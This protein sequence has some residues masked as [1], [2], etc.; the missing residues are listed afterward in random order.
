V[1]SLIPECPHGWRG[2]VPDPKDLPDDQFR[3]IRDLIEE[4]VKALLASLGGSPAV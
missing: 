1:R 3:A 4:K 2:N